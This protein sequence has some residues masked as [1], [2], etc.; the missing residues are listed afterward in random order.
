MVFMLGG[1]S[2]ASL[3]LQD[4]ITRIAGH[5]LGLPPTHP[6]QLRLLVTLRA[7]LARRHFVPLQN[8]LHFEIDLATREKAPKDTKAPTGSAADEKTRK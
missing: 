1:G 5:V 7:K 6:P 8:Q 4:G 3:Q 2:A